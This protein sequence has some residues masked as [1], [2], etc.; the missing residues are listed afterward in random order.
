M[1][2]DSWQKLRSSDASFEAE[3]SAGTATEIK[4]NAMI[5]ENRRVEKSNK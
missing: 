5:E 1:Y 4:N 3:F 2:M